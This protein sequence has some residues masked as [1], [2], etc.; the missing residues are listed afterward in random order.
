MTVQP[1]LCRTWS[2]PKLLV[3][4]RTCSIILNHTKFPFVS[5]RNAAASLS[6]LNKSWE[7]SMVRAVT[8]SYLVVESAHSFFHRQGLLLDVAKIQTFN[9]KRKFTVYLFTATNKWA[10][11]W[12]NQQSAYA[13]TKTQ[14]SFAVT[15]KLISAVVL[16]TR[17]VQFLFYL[18]PKFQASSSFLCLYRPVCVGPGRKPHC[19][20]SHEAAQVYKLLI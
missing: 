11:S 4:S 15:A 9:I 2:E 13:K 8:G 19:W 17:I 5:V 3:F 18:N 1:G 10:A 16:A 7:I 20:F 14:I 6:H 12:E